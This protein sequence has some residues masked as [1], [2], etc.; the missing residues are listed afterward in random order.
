MS[1]MRL[2][3]AAISCIEK[4]TFPIAISPLVA[5]DTL[6]DERVFACRAVSELFLTAIVNSSIAAAVSSRLA[7]CSS[8]R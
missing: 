7:A 6:T 3:E 1:D 5:L 8:V 2:D 4:L